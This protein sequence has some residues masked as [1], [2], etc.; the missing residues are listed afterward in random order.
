MTMNIYYISESNNEYY[1][2]RT[3]SGTYIEKVS[4]ETLREFAKTNIVIGYNRVT[5]EISVKTADDVF[6]YVK[7]KAKL[8]KIDDDLDRGSSVT[9]NKA[10]ITVDTRTGVTIITI[11][12]KDATGVDLCSLYND[13]VIDYDEI[14]SSLSPETNEVDIVF[15]FSP[16]KGSISAKDSNF[17]LLKCLRSIRVLNDDMFSMCTVINTLFDFSYKCYEY[18]E[19]DFTNLKF[20]SQFKTNNLFTYVRGNVM[21][22]DEF[23]RNGEHHR[24]FQFGS[25]SD[26]EFWKI[27]R[28]N[29]YLL[30]TTNVGIEKLYC[31]DSVHIVDYLGSY[32]SSYNIPVKTLVLDKEIQRVKQIQ[33]CIGKICTLGISKDIGQVSN[34]V[35]IKCLTAIIKQYIY[36]EN[37]IYYLA[38]KN[39]ISGLSFKKAITTFIKDGFAGLPDELRNIVTKETG[40]TEISKE[41]L[42][43]E[44]KTTLRD[45]NVCW[46]CTDI[47]SKETKYTE[48]NKDLLKT[49]FKNVF[50]GFDACWSCT[51]AVSNYSVYKIETE[52][53]VEEAILWVVL[54]NMF[55][56]LTLINGTKTS[57]GDL[58]EIELDNARFRVL[59]ER[60]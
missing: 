19:A 47:V 32:L 21:L 35:L 36:S 12:S 41:Q 42:E 26:T 57:S 56:N 15:D 37:R 8:L 53:S 49:E 10:N 18:F 52:L 2:V 39:K 20:P 33:Q 6:D 28:N 22:P 45:F 50:K 54:L 55:G 51:D 43:T 16:F 48:V 46:C 25:I 24:L 31:K 11:T 59:Q 40:Y 23:Y 1:E 30:S 58:A 3:V 7:S 60:V 27:C 38:T 34:E 17:R 29:K 14:K 5:G 13:F 9:I 4:E 44:F